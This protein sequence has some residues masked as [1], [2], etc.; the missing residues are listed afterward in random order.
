MFLSFLVRIR[1]V[2]LAKQFANTLFVLNYCRFMRKMVFSKWFAK[3]LCK[4]ISDGFM[5]FGGQYEKFATY[6]LN[7]KFPSSEDNFLTATSRIKLTPMF[8]HLCRPR[9]C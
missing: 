8:F 9:S 5:A 2:A 7:K 3:K 6:G 1:K 4:L